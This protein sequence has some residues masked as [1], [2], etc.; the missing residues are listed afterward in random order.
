MILVSNSMYFFWK[1]RSAILQYPYCIICHANNK[2]TLRKIR[3]SHLLHTAFDAG[4]LINCRQQCSVYGCVDGLA[5]MLKTFKWCFEYFGH[6]STCIL[7]IFL[8][9]IWVFIP[10]VS[11]IWDSTFLN[12][13]SL[14]SQ[15]GF[16]NLKSFLNVT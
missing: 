8:V 16:S 7:L 11:L 2:K 1:I 12:L 5:F 13:K 9:R 6:V 3:S 14:I 15:R 10:C 4:Q